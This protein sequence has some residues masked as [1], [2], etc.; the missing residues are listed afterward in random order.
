MVSMAETQQENLHFLDYWRVV[1]S[2]KEVVIAVFL[3]VVLT[4]IFVTYAMP[5]VYMSTCLVQVKEDQPAVSVWGQEGGRFDPLFLRTQFEI[6]Q[7]GPVIEEVIRRRELAPK[8]A[9]AYGFD[10]FSSDKVFQKAVRLVTKALKVQQYR[11]TNLIQIQMY[12]SEPKDSVALECPMAADMVAE[13]YK[14]QSLA[15]SHRIS[16]SQLKAM[17]KLLEER[18]KAVE[19]ATANVEKIRKDSK[20]DMMSSGSRTDTTLGK[21]SLALL[22]ES[23]IVARS[24]LAERKARH[25]RVMAL[26]PDELRNVAPLLVQDAG[27]MSLLNAKREAEVERSRLLQASLGEKHPDVVAVQAAIAELEIKIDEAVK[28]LKISVQT[29]FEAAQAQVD[30]LEKMVQEVKDR[31]RASAGAEYREFDKAVEE[32]EHAKQIRNALETRYL[33]ERIEQNVPHTTVEIIENAKPPDLDD[34][35]SPNFLINI[36]LSILVGLGAGIGLAYFVEY[37]DTSVKTMEDVE[38]YMK[39]PVLGV[40]PQKVRAFVE[41]GADGAAAES[42]RMLRASIQF[43]EK[44]K[45]GKTL[46]VTS[47]SVA[48]G[49]SLTVFNLGFVCSQL[50]DRV[51]IVDSDLHRPRQHKILGV[52]NRTG[53]ANVLVGEVTLDQAI[54]ETKVPGLKFLP[55]GRLTAG[56]HGVLDTRRMRE[57]A[58]DLK[59]RFDLIIF[60]APPVIGVSDASLLVREVDGVLQVIQHRKYPRSVSS[61]AKD[62][63]ENVGGNL[64]GVVLNNINVSRDYSY[65]YR[66]HYYY[67][68][69]SGKD[70]GKE[71]AKEP[72]APAAPTAKA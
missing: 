58:K 69:K 40:I 48:E 22:D 10:H 36:L 7:S 62:M 18:Q 33:Q 67:Y 4:G 27:L 28:A 23:R 5:K 43:S 34:P 21:R 16:D 51:L 55:S 20:I 13:V 8:L 49:K 19:D 68:P 66:Y 60:D 14:E 32:L 72:A 11:E 37:V 46:C 50:G 63:I 35:V 47:G 44:W 70:G 3:L 31:E 25:E 1:R 24:K 45:Q 29:E 39:V 41:K 17:Q 53:L 12:L 57:L 30:D 15:R 42:Y 2:R 61:R 54:Q 64:L 65:Y 38:R 6:I 26:K 52:S 56:I 59:Q 71:R 9:R